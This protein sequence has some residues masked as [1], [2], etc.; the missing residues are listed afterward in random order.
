MF[1]MGM[2]KDRQG[3]MIN[4]VQMAKHICVSG[5]ESELCLVV[6][7]SKAEL[8][9]VVNCLSGGIRDVVGILFV[10]IEDFRDNCVII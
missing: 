6:F 2:K 10:W 7:A 1:V 9:G 5:H 4:D 3:M 8:K